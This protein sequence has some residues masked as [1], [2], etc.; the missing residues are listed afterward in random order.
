MD[1]QFNDALK[2]WCP[3]LIATAWDVRFLWNWC[4]GSAT[5][6]KNINIKKANTQKTCFSWY[7]L[8]FVFVVLNE[9]VALRMECVRPGQRKSRCKNIQ[10]I[11]IRKILS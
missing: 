6:C 3:Q 9:Y 10:I 5:Y 8:F 7:Q 2:N 1:L 4:I 11:V